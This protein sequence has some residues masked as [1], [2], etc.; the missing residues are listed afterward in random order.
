MEKIQPDL[1]IG[2]LK[3][4]LFRLFIMVTRQLPPHVKIMCHTPVSDAALDG[5]TDNTRAHIYEGLKKHKF[6]TK[7]HRLTPK[8]VNTAAE[9]AVSQCSPT[10][11]GII[12]ALAGNKQFDELKRFFPPGDG[13]INRIWSEEGKKMNKKIE[14][15]DAEKLVFVMSGLYSLLVWKVTYSQRKY[16]EWQNR[17]G[18]EGSFFTQL[19]DECKEV[20]TDNITRNLKELGYVVTGYTCGKITRQGLRFIAKELRAAFKEPDE[21]KI[22]EALAGGYRQKIREFISVYGAVWNVEH[23]DSRM[24]DAFIKIIYN[25]CGRI[26]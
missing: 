4:V 5:Y 11:E 8:G 15:S 20:D 16:I 7:D 25:A 14:L 2:L 12:T 1:I 26:K 13:N 21:D 9:Y 6:L 18:T 19:Y 17:M 24:L 10:E 3:K 23:K 22:I